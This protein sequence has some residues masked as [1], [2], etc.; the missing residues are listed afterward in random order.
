MAL[1]VLIA[2]LFTFSAQALLI[3][4]IFVDCSNVLNC[5]EIRE[6]F[7]IS[8]VSFNNRDQLERII[9]EISKS[10]NYY[11]AFYK[12]EKQGDGVI[13]SLNFSPKPVIDDIKVNIDGDFD[14][15]KFPFPKKDQVYSPEL[16]NI[17]VVD[18]KT[19]LESNGYSRPEIN[20]KVKTKAQKVSLFIDIK[21]GE[22]NTIKRPILVSDIKDL[23]RIET[24]LSVF[25][26]E[27]WDR[28][29]FETTLEGIEKSYQ[30]EGFFLFNTEIIEVKQKSKNEIEPFVRVDFGKRFGLE[31]KG[32][33]SVSRDDLNKNI[34]KVIVQ[35]QGEVEAQQI[36]ELI[37]EQYRDLG[38][39]GT[40]V[41]VRRA[42]FKTEEYD[43]SNFFIEIDEGGKIIIDKLSFLGNNFFTYDEVEN[44][45]KTQGT[46]LADRGFYDEE[47][48]E[49]FPNILRRTYLENGF[50]FIKIIGPEIAFNKDKSKVSIEY[51]II[52][53]KQVVWENFIF[54]G[55]PEEL[56][57]VAL[58]GVINKIESPLNLVELKNDITRVENNLKEE[59]YYFAKIFN[60]SSRYVVEYDEDFGS[61]NLN[62]KINLGRKITVGNIKV[63]GLSRT[64]KEVIDREIRE[65]NFKKGILVTPSRITELRKTIQSLG[66]FSTVNVTPLFI[67][68]EK[69]KVSIF[70]NLKE[71]DFGFFELAPGFRSDIGFKLS[72]A[73]GYSNVQGLNHTAIVKAQINERLDFSSFD[74]ERKASSE[75]KLEYELGLNYDWPFLFRTPLLNTP[76]NF[77]S[78]L[79]DSRRRFRSFDAD[80]R[81]LSGTFDFFLWKSDIGNYKISANLV[82]ELEKIR[83]YDATDP[84]D[85]GDFT[86]VSFTPG[87]IF[88]FRNREINP[89]KGA[90]FKLNLEMARP[91]YGSKEGEKEINY[92]RLTSRNAFYWPISDKITLAVS[93]AF[94]MQEN[95]A[96]DNNPIPD[97]KVF[98]LT[99]VDRVRGFIDTEINRLD[100]PD[101]GFIDVDDF[102]VI[103]KV[104]FSNFKIEPRFH[105]S[106]DI[107]I[108][109]FFD[110]GRIS[111]DTFRPF[112]VRKSVG[113]SFKYLTPV[114]TLNFDYGVK[115]DRQILTEGGAEEQEV[116]GRFHL[117]LGF[118]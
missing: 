80:I 94:G 84:T 49:D 75:R 102:D 39:F 41:R 5:D 54:D 50:V 20:L 81:R 31:L 82:P 88:D 48:M 25:K 97:I 13:I 22:L 103:D 57:P 59:G 116:A 101:L 3:K 45:F 87:L 6:R 99:G 26:G 46:V 77:S 113:V 106:D 76:M 86:I 64:K 28:T 69:E 98:R 67:D 66:L 21:L 33:H 51:R 109:P 79:S 35:L 8:E 114:G 7:D 91:E 73:L 29:T 107:I 24:Q 16:Q 17:V 27:P 9:K 105:Y 4:D 60:K 1:R 47:F 36:I 93:A 83:Q 72:A 42:D 56:Y 110:A 43:N 2:L 115:L 68:N 95:F 53:G 100:R 34:R 96:E 52:E 108:A 92:D 14:I 32:N 23:S 118:F 12:I 61:A 58:K 18:L 90:I 111:V 74:E 40:K 112:D 30:A 104:F 19:F 71:K 11:K 15:S 117:N 65:L 85:E 44:I 70:I 78:Q 89:S 62:L 55:V 38:M 63:V 37:E 10:I